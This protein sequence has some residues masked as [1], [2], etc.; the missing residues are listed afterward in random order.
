MNRTSLLDA[1]RSPMAAAALSFLAVVAAISAFA[2][3]LAPCDPEA[4][5]MG[6]RLAP[7]S[8]SHPLG[9]DHLGRDVLS[10]L[11][12]GGR[13]TLLLAL[14][15]S[16]ATMAIGLALGIVSGYFGGFAD[17]A[18]QWFVQL[19]QG[20]PGLSFMLAIAGTLGPGAASLFIAVVIT[21]WADFSRIVR[22]ETLKLREEH[23]VEAVRAMGS[24][25]GRIMLRHLMPNLLGP[26]VV[27]F[28]VRI[29]RTMLAIASLSFLGL[30]LQP[31]LPDWG[32]M[33]SDARTYF[34]SYPHL[35]IL[36]GMCIAAVSLAINLLG[37]ALRDGWDARTERNGEEW[38]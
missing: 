20:L 28:T 11:L 34:R 26:I 17:D 9:T 6:N 27:L 38:R 10:R 21:S 22:G 15:A 5:D 29:G 30:G 13:H 24:G 18:I 1:F 33:V 3:L 2:P 12:H 36:P 37:D 35:M 4:V 32:V 25:H 7:F 14:A 16:V 19:F 23:Y 8:L 31:P